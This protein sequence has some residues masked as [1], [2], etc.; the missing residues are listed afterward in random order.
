[1]ATNMEGRTRNEGTNTGAVDA[2]PSNERKRW[3]RQPNK[4]KRP[5]TITKAKDRDRGN[6]KQGQEKRRY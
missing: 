5:T 1:M 4:R 6:D 2:K 3:E